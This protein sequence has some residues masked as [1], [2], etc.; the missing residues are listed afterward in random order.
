[1]GNCCVS[2]DQI[3]NVHKV[4][5]QQN[6]ST[7]NKSIVS[8]ISF[9]SKSRRTSVYIYNNEDIFKNYSFEKEIGKGFFGKVSIVMPKNDKNKKYACKSI[10]KSKLNAI[11]ISNLL[12]E[13]ETLSL[14][15][16]PNI[17]KFY[18]TYNDQN[19]FHI[20]ME[21][22][23]GGDL[24]SRG[25]RDRISHKK[26][27]N[28]K[29]ACHLIFKI[30]S[31]IVHCHSLGIV[32]RDLKPENILFENCSQFS[33][34]KI[35]DFGLS[36]KYL[37]E[38]DLH[39]V[40]GS[41]FYV[42]PEVLDGIYDEKC[43]VWSIGILTYCLLYGSPPF[44][45]S[46]KEEV[47]NKIR[48]QPLKFSHDHDEQ[49]SKSAK[50]FIYTELTKNQKKRPT[51]QELLKNRWLEGE[52][53]DEINPKKLNITILQKI[54]SFHKPYRFTQRVV[55]LMIKIMPNEELSKFKELFNAIDK[56]K[57]GLI[58]I[59]EFS[60]VIKE[61]KLDVSGS[62]IAKVG[63]KR[64]GKYLKDEFKSNQPMINFTSF[65]AA[66]IDKNIIDNKPRLQEVFNILDTDKSGQLTVFS[67]QK[68]FERT[69]KK[70]T[71]EDVKDMF[72]EIGLDETDTV[73]FDDFCRIISKDL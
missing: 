48:H 55:E 21:L 66:V 73:S 71:Y 23:T 36:R 5:F 54:N 69:G 7:E 46:N 22:C 28:E 12:R 38:D 50:M 59:E 53:N 31:A 72:T 62:Q 2:K 42:A 27:Y 49:I 34:I 65:I 52:F 56:E 70:T 68:A 57:I 4:N 3:I 39:S 51:A 60:D 41:P 1:M 40:V 63:T 25:Y 14:V 15:D 24:F 30:T 19:S 61:L 64:Y 32:H 11:K 33:D 10:D 29:D 20:I 35:I 9:I 58:S 13:I 8:S 18:E 17:V 6:H 44:V 37:R 47:F 43:D 26:K 16:H 67:V 45:S